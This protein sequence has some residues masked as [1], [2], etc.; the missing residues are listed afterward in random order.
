MP[1]YNLKGNRESNVIHHE[2]YRKVVLDYLTVKG[3]QEIT[4]SSIEGCLTDIIL[5]KHEYPD[6]PETHVELKWD[7]FSINNKSIRKEIS[8]YFLLYLRLRPNRR[9]KFHIFA[10]NI[11]NKKLHNDLF[12]RLINE[13]IQS[14]CQKIESDLNE[15]DRFFFKNIDA[16]EKL[17]FFVDTTLYKG[18]I[19]DLKM[20]IF[21]LTE[22]YPSDDDVHLRYSTIIEKNNLKDEKETIISNIKE[23]KNITKIWRAKTDA[24]NDSEVRDLM[25][26]SKLREV[27]FQNL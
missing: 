15:S 14:I 17:E 19:D 1:Y 6:E 24:I 8:E 21:E 7:E 22:D 18:D 26:I 16:E 23:V 27:I 11:L 9:F 3:Y 13:E 12:N 25:D 4:S 5:K 2:N 10:K 20:A